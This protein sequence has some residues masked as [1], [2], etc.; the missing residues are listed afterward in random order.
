M[1]Q[2]TRLSDFGSFNLGYSIQQQKFCLLTHE[3]LLVHP[4]LLLLNLMRKMYLVIR[5]RPFP[6]FANKSLNTLK[7]TKLVTWLKKRF[8]RRR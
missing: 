4:R 1:S 7:L 5:S 8:V 3:R 2:R 6:P